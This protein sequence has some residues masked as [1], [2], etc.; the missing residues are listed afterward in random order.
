[1]LRLLYAVGVQSAMRIVYGILYHIASTSLIRQD[2]RKRPTCTHTAQ[3]PKLV[4]QKPRKLK[5]FC[6]YFN[7]TRSSSCSFKI[8]LTFFATVDLNHVLYTSPLNPTGGLP[9]LRASLPPLFCH[10]S[11]GPAAEA[12]V[13]VRV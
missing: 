12:V 5:N 2:I 6:T 10:P 7:M 11:Y 4:E 8:P 3:V 1:M 9:C 13:P